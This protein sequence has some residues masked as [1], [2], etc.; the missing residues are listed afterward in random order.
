VFSFWGWEKVLENSPIG[1]SRQERISSALFGYL[2]F[3]VAVALLLPV[4]SRLKRIRIIEIDWLSDTGRIFLPWAIGLVLVFVFFRRYI[5]KYCTAVAGWLSETP[6]DRNRWVVVGVCLLIFTSYS[7]QLHIGISHRGVPGWVYAG[8][9]ENIKPE[10]PE[11]LSLPADVDPAVFA[12]AMQPA[13]LPFIHRSGYAT[14]EVMFLHFK[15][16]S[17]RPGNNELAM[18]S[19]PKA[20]FGV[21]NGQVTHEKEFFE[22]IRH[23]FVNRRAGGFIMPDAIAY[24]SHLNYQRIDYTSYPPATELV[25]VTLWNMTVKVDDK[26]Q[27]M[28]VVGAVKIAQVNG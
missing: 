8:L 10:A 13:V 4:L 14:S 19:W 24:P 28:N 2:G 5:R 7:W 23:N 27:Q 26:S 12:S 11:T 22:I 21:E 20:T 6:S 15:D 3:V 1:R 25:S 18:V 16:G 17:I 9:P